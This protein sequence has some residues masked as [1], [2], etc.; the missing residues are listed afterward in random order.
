MK[1]Q[2]NIK[3]AV[4]LESFFGFEQHE[5]FY[6]VNNE[7]LTINDIDP[8]LNVFK[9]KFV[10]EP[11]QPDKKEVYYTREGDLI[12]GYKDIRIERYAFIPDFLEARPLS[13]DLVCAGRIKNKEQMPFIWHLLKERR[14]ELIL[15]QKENNN[16]Q[17][18][19]KQFIVTEQ[20]IAE[21]KQVSDFQRFTYELAVL[22]ARQSL[23]FESIYNLLRCTK[24]V[25]SKSSIDYYKI[26]RR[27]NSLHF[28]TFS[29]GNGV[30]FLYDENQM[31]EMKLLKKSKHCQCHN[32]IELSSTKTRA[33]YNRALNSNMCVIPV[34]L[35]AEAESR[36]K[37]FSLL[38]I[39][40]KH[41][42]IQVGLSNEK[43]NDSEIQENLYRYFSEILSVI[44]FLYL[45]DIEEYNN[46]VDSI[47]E[48][49][50]SYNTILVNTIYSII[51]LESSHFKHKHTATGTKSLLSKQDMLIFNQIKIYCF[52]KI[53]ETVSMSQNLEILY[54]PNNR[55]DIV[56][57]K[58]K[59]LEEEYSNNDR[60]EEVWE[61]FMARSGKKMTGNNFSRMIKQYKEDIIEYKD[62]L[63]KLYS[64][65]S[66]KGF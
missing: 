39:G 42:F 19:F 46:K 61:N 38:S 21:C 18:I 22:A 31:Q 55:K 14:D 59:V 2:N 25:I 37:I 65:I 54:T 35:I 20:N 63:P 50:L 29:M 15:N 36:E 7:P 47:L 16:L 49:T 48:S 52:K 32:F 6:R 12:F 43:G 64:Y 30:L 60:Q 45:T 53:C 66:K 1:G 17:D 5:D 9:N 10:S 11:K 24:E 44:N 41:L 8:V 27:L 57:Y 33:L 51:L 62:R 40:I 58:L 26:N 3:Q 4:T 34:S 28:K 23:P 56:F 13:N